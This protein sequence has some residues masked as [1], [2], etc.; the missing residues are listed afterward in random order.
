VP[1]GRVP[2]GAVP[3]IIPEGGVPEGFVPFT[4]MS[5]G[6]VPEGVCSDDEELPDCT[7]DWTCPEDAAEVLPD[8][9]G[10][11]PESCEVHPAAKRAAARRTD[12]ITNNMLDF[13][14]QIT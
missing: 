8:E 11:L 7:V 9:V 12:A 2:E 13:F 4:A 1:D 6:G 3:F 10:E 5:A 14:M